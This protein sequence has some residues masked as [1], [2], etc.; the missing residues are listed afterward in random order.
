MPKTRHSTTTN[1]DVYGN[2]PVNEIQE[3]RHEIEQLKNKKNPFFESVT[4]YFKN[5]KDSPFTTL[6]GVATGGSM[7][8]EAY[9]SKNAVTGLQGVGIVLGLGGVSEQSNTIMYPNDTT[10]I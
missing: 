7:I 3:L 8:Y 9:L 10:I 1:K 4:N 5:F 6:A 2:E